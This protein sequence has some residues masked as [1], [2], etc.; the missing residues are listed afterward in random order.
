MS[1]FVL[2]YCES[3]MGYQTVELGNIVPCHGKARGSTPWGRAKP[4][5]IAY[6]LNLH[7]VLNGSEEFDLP[8]E[9]L[10]D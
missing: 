7:V 3:D 5:L 9:L 10:E 2:F 6:L 1:S 4:D 8:V